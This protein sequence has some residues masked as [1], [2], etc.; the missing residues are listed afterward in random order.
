MST[1]NAFHYTFKE[2]EFDPAVAR[3]TALESAVTALQAVSHIKV[4]SGTITK[5]ATSGEAVTIGTLPAGGI[6]VGALIHVSQAFNGTGPTL[7]VGAGTDADA[8][9][10]NTDVTEGTIGSYEK[11]PAANNIIGATGGTALTATLTVTGTPTTGAATVKV[12]YI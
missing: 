5:A 12:F 2:E 8:L 4:I 3:I 1:S 6:V 9:I 11:W 7:D 10:A